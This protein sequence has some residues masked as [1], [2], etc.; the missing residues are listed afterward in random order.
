MNEA[1]LNGLMKLFAIIVDVHKVGFEVAARDVVA[2]YLEKQFSKEWLARYLDDFDRYMKEYHELDLLENAVQVNHEKISEICAEMVEEMEQEQKVWLM[3]QLI[4]FVGDSEFTGPVELDYVKTV[5]RSFNIEQDEFE[6]SRQFILGDQYSIPFNHRLLIIDSNEEFEHEVVKHIYNPHLRGRILVLRLSSTNTFLIRY[7]GEYNLFLNGHNV[8]VNRTY[9]FALGSVIRSPRIDPVYYSQVAGQFIQSKTAARIH[10]VADEIEFRFKGSMDG[11]HRFSFM[12]ESGQLIGIMGGSG[13]GKSTLLNVLNGN[14]PLYNGQITIN[15]YDLHRDKEHLDGVIGYVP[16]ED[17]LIEELT[18]YQNLYYNAKLC[19]EGF[20]E[21]R[22][23]EQ[24]AEVIEKFDLV[25]AR[26]L[27]V[28]DPLNKILSGGQ[29]KRLNIALE[30]MREP[31]IL[32]VD[33][34]TSGLSSMDSEKVMNLLKRQVL[35]GKLVMCNIHQPSSDIFKLLDKLIILDQGGRVIYFGNPVDAVVYFKSMSHY[36]KPDESECPSCG[37]VNSEQILRIIEARM[38]NEYGKQIRK[39]KRSPQ[40]WEG[41]YREKIEAVNPIRKPRR[42]L[43]LPQN[44]FNIPQR[45]K[46]FQIYINRDLKAKL[47]NRQYMVITLMEAPLLAVIL[48]YFTKYISGTAEDPNAYVFGTNENLPAYLFMAVVVALFLGMIIS[49]EEII[50]DRRIMKRESFLNLS[51]FSY[52]NSKVLVLMGISAIQTLLF[53]LLANHILEIKGLTFEYWAVLFTA[54]TCA[55]LI[56]LNLSAAL[57]TVVAVYV[58]IPFILVPQLLFSGVIVDFT[59]LHRRITT[60]EYVPIVGDL[61]TSR[62]AYEAL[63]V[64]QFRDNRFEKYFF[65]YEQQMSE[66]SYKA[67][68]LVPELEQELKETNRLLSNGH[69]DRVDSHLKLLNRELPKLLQYQEFEGGKEKLL[70]SV[71]VLKEEGIAPLQAWLEQVK[72]NCWYRYNRASRQR[73]AAYEKMSIRMGGEQATFELKQDYYNEALA[74]LVLNRQGVN[75][76]INYE[77]KLIQAKDPI[78]R[79]PENRF[80]RG[81]FYAPFKR[82]G[83]W[84]ISTF[85]FNLLVIWLTS[86]FFYIALYFDWLRKL[87]QTLEFVWLRIIPEGEFRIKLKRQ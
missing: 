54:S 87:N 9:L 72:R 30:L 19:F 38:M 76:I 24:I 84:L 58:S 8:K 15:G 85:W 62:W 40:E 71:D 56:G 79:I 37:N 47:S 59:K 27:K 77:G 44:F 81:H 80:G 53:V 6:N 3:L 57:N 45:F 82:V 70:L 67:S 25:E 63:V 16:Q 12:A 36:V 69:S 10:Y 75:K 1:V 42:K 66:A 33:E 46:Q 39:R 32:Y 21:E 61:M 48:G 78:F 4:E 34:P 22:I 41:M 52:L 55:N 7:F 73:D 83:N 65:P 60:Q 43:R 50:H 35:K 11:L 13:T 64:E 17:L 68:Y 29:R 14:L 20:S 18:V 26:D 86:I 2:Q 51:R 28:G 23:E 31:S 49:A 5:A 74:N